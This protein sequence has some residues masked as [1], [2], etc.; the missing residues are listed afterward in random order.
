MT[1]HE[2]IK[3]NYTKATKPYPIPSRA[4]KY[5]CERA[6]HKHVF[7]CEFTAAMVECGH[8]AIKD[9]GTQAFFK[10]KPTK[11]YR[12]SMKQTVFVPLAKQPQLT[13][14]EEVCH[15]PDRNK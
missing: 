11:A 15:H 13:N 2:W 10:I 9:D 3:L 1:I 4:L 14:T 5:D 7:E 12:E 8:G 6:L